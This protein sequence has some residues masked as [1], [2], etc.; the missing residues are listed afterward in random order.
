MSQKMY[1]E[2]TA[3]KKLVIIAGAGHGESYYRD[4]EKYQKAVRTFLKQCEEKDKVKE[5]SQIS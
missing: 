2:C 4:T 5:E 3:E 1:E